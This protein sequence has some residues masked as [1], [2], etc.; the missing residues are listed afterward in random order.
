MESAVE[1][2]IMHES[3]NHSGKHHTPCHESIVRDYT[4]TGMGT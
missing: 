1:A 2:G 3:M 4:N